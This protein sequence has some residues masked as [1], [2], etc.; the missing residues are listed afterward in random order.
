MFL[1]PQNSH[2]RLLRGHD[3]EGGAFVA[4]IAEC[5]VMRMVQKLW[6]NVRRPFVFSAGINW[7]EAELKNTRVSVE[8]KNRFCSMQIWLNPSPLPSFP[9]VK[10]ETFGL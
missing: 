1:G 9:C 7:W 5:T 4:S 3:S 6:S 10:A 2:F 8:T